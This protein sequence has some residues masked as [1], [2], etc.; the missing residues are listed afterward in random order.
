MSSGDNDVPAPPDYA[1]LYQ[2][3]ID[4]FLKNY[5]NLLDKEGEARD[6]YDPQRIAHQQALQEEFGP[7]QVQQQLDALK[8]FDPQSFAV[9]DEL[10]KRVLGDLESGYD[11][12]DEY[13]REIEQ[14]IRGA[15]TARGNAYGEGPAS[16]EASVK[17][18]AALEMYQQRLSNAG[19]FLAGPTPTQQSLAIQG[20]QPDRGMSYVTPTAGTQGVNFGLSN[21]QNLLAQQ[22]LV[23]QQKGGWT[24]AALGAAS[25]YA[26]GGWTGAVLG[27]AA[28]YYSD[29]RLKENIRHICKTA[30]GFPMVCFNFKGRKE[31]FIGTLAED[32]QA[33]RPDA[34]T[35]ENGF[36]KVDY[37]KLDVP[38]YELKGSPCLG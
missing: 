25:G 20:V 8:Q 17:G 22:Q 18:R 24:D 32:V 2:S 29:S 33:I 15:Q 38:F 6:I 30:L 36:L 11:L 28:G 16:A 4:V 27:G 5:L 21:Y 13:S 10:S 3:G 1:K 34:V 14:S 7:I 19:N 26:T 23:G 37:S 9:R 35:E 12:G 31:Q